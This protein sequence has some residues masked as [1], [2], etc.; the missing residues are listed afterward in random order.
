LFQVHICYSTGLT[1]RDFVR[2]DM[3]PLIRAVI[4]ESQPTHR[5]FP[6]SYL[7]LMTIT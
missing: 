1:V 2:D 3:E 6:P 4:G 5:A 7:V